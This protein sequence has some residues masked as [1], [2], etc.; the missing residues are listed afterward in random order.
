MDPYIV[1]TNCVLNTAIITLLERRTSCPKGVE[2]DTEPWPFANSRCSYA[3]ENTAFKCRQL[4]EEELL[5]CHPHL[6]FSIF[7]AARFY[8]VNSKALDSNV[9]VNLHSLSFCLHTCS[10]R[11]LL[12]RTCETVIRT[13]VAEYRTPVSESKVPRVF[14][15]LRNSALDILGALQTWVASGMDVMSIST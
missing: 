5:S 15:D 11:W 13:A 8:I 7:V 3:A 9:P 4:S 14:Y 10:K 12:A 6:I 2:Q 1:L